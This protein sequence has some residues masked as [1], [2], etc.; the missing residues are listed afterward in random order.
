MVVCVLLFSASVQAVTIQGRATGSFCCVLNAQGNPVNSV[1]NADGTITN[2]NAGSPQFV[3]SNNDADVGGATIVTWGTAS[4]A[5]NGTVNSFTFDGSGS[6]A[7]SLP[8]STTA[9]SLFQIGSFDYYNA[10]TR[11]DNISGISF[12]LDMEV[13]NNNMS[14]SFPT[15]QFDLSITNTPDNS[16]PV[17]SQDF[18]TIANTWLIL[19]DGTQ[20][21]LN[22]P[23]GFE[24]DGFSY[25]FLLNGFAII[26]PATGL[27]MLDSNGEYVFSNS[28]SAFENN[29]TEAA[30]F[31]SIT[32]VTAVP[33]P[34]AIW[35]MISGLVLLIG[36][37]RS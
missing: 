5:S 31:G 24:L 15:L 14:M 8:G 1:T 27:P 23:M 20:A 2:I 18:V 37:R 16:N 21:A 29:L 26:D 11:Q 4:N 12:F 34:G 3:I 9:D 19:A 7:G 17:A 25:E 36:Y 6:D 28:T 13:I 32:Q 33:L 10:A 30:I 35:L 22:G